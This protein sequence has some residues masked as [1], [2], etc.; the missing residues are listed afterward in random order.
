[1][2]YLVSGA[3]SRRDPQPFTVEVVSKSGGT[4]ETAAAFRV[5]REAMQRLYGKDYARRIVAI[6]D[7]VRGT[8]RKLAR[9]E[10]FEVLPIPPDVAGRYS[11]LSAV[12]LFPAA[13]AG[14]EIER[15]V[16]GAAT[17]ARHCL[18]KSGRENLAL[19]HA[20]LM[21]L[22]MR[23]GR[24]LT[25][26]YCWGDALRGLGR[27]HDQL[28]AESLG[29]DGRG[30][31]PVSVIVPGELHTRGQEVQEGARNAVVVHLC[32]ERAGRALQIPHVKDDLDG[33][34]Y[35]AGKPMADLLRAAYEGTALAYAVDERPGLALRLPN[36]DAASLGE[37]FYFFEMAIA[38]E[39]HL[40]GVNPFDQPGVEGY[41]SFMYSLLGRSDAKG[42][43]RT[44][45]VLGQETQ[46]AK[47]SRRKGRVVGRIEKVRDD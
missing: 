2:D 14:V 27:W 7:P 43:E 33:L 19:T 40:A 20:A 15:L 21:S 3:R 41:K 24:A 46:V 11:V 45:R 26:L 4:L 30:R 44:L 12:G 34:S 36:T 6:T 17:M 29:K 16:G 35:L 13:M 28:V 22:S 39:A 37:L 47:R 8:L 1:V 31:V 10:G 5:V 38:I 18:N 42:I 25:Y 32:V 9:A 23:A